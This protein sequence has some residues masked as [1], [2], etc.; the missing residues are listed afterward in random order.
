MKGAPEG[1]ELVLRAA[2]IAIVADEKLEAV[3]ETALGRVCEALGV[4]PA[5]RRGARNR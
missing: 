5:V 1:R 3:E 4:D 2:P